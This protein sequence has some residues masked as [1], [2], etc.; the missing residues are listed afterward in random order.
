M[1]EQRSRRESRDRNPGVPTDDLN[2]ERPPW[3]RPWQ[4]VADTLRT[5]PR[6]GL[7]KADVESR[8]ERVGANRLRQVKR[9]SAWRILVRQVQS[10]IALLLLGAA[11]IAFAFGETREALSI[12]AVIAIN[13]ALGFITELKAVRSME[14]LRSLGRVRTRARRDGEVISLAAW[15]LVP[16]DTVILEA[17]DLVPADLRVTDVSKL[18]ADE[19]TLTGES[20][21]VGKAPESLGIETSLA[22]RSNMLYR[23]TSLTRGS[24]EAIVVDTGMRTEIGHI[25]ELV[26]HADAELTPLER[27]LNRLATRLVWVTVGIAAV[28]ALSGV[29]AGKELFLMIQTAIALAVA[30]VPEG[31]PIVATVALAR[32]MWRMAQRNALLNRLAAVEALGSTTI[33]CSDKTGT[34]TENRMTVTE[35]VIDGRSIKVSDETTDDSARFRNDGNIL[36]PDDPLL[37]SAL[38]TAVLCNNAE[39]PDEPGQN[40]GAGDPLEISLL[41]LGRK[42]GLTRHDL[43]SRMPEAREEAFDPE[44]KKMATFHPDREGYRVAVKG[45]PESVLKVSSRALTREGERSLDDDMRR[46]WLAQNQRMADDGLRVLALATKVVDSTSDA[47]YENLVFVGLVGIV[48]PPR[49]DARI[50]IEACHA[51]G[52]RVIMATGDQ[53]GTARAI[54]AA[55]GMIENGDTSIV[56]GDEFDALISGTPDAQQRLLDAQVFAR[57]TP[58][59]KLDLVALHQDNGAIVAMTGDGVNDAPALRQA[60]IGIAMGQRGTQVA[61]EAADMVLQDDKLSTVVMAVEQ[62]RIIFDNIRR[63]VFYLLSCNVSEVMLVAI[64]PL[65]QMPLPITPLQILFLNL[66]TDVFPALALG[67]GE[68]DGHT[69]ERPPR[70]PKVA[71]IGRDDW[72]TIASYGLLLTASVFGSLVVATEYLELGPSGAV[73]LSFLTLAFAQLWHVFNMRHATSAPVRNDITRNPYVWAALLLCTGLL[74]AAVYVPSLALALDIVPPDRQAWMV[75]AGFSIL[76]L[77]VG[78][79]AKIVRHRISGVP[80]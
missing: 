71:I 42:A 2:L 17:G 34:L 10:L 25:A 16:G 35:L 59:Q 33:I 58:Q 60:D 31:L 11:A 56:H 68:G 41:V 50:A 19:S 36:T 39:V 73:T 1:S 6:R 77:I 49:A 13:T 44:S 57:V 20:M 74:L 4:E 65:A 45:A 47:P 55:L 80:R 70:D 62:G 18:Q 52:I 23:G 40:G 54:G 69:M 48:D 7:S 15:E 24:A 51:A 64:A 38:E 29:L 46:Q 14:A 72:V 26:E 21:P 53:P 67:V 27:R 5:D 8:R 75:I 22:E 43:M 76:P 30:T 79:L 78:Q 32:G 37:R 3:S 61:A 9:E 28:V 63:F 12:G 66:V